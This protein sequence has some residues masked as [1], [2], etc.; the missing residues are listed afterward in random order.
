[1]KTLTEVNVNSMNCDA[2][3]EYYMKE[4]KDNNG[5]IIW[6]DPKGC[7]AKCR[8]GV[9]RIVIYL[10]DNEYRTLTSVSLTPG[11]IKNLMQKITEI[12]SIIKDEFID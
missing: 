5:N 12:E 11:T 6:V 4:I 1:M 3:I 8:G 9:D 10:P 2:V 7:I